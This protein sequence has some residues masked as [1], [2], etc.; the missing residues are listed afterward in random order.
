M[1]NE[2]AMSMDVALTDPYVDPS[3]IQTAVFVIVRPGLDVNAPG[4][5]SRYPFV[6]LYLKLAD[7]LALPESLNNICVLEPPT[8]PPPLEPV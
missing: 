7:P 6:L 3:L 1:G 2:L 5:S 4:P 8:A